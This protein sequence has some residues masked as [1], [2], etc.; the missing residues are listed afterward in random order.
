MCILSSNV[1][2]EIIKNHNIFNNRFESMHVTYEIPNF[3]TFILFAFQF[4]TS[5]K[6]RFIYYEKYDKRLRKNGV[7]HEKL[8]IQ[9]K[10]LQDN[11]KNVT[12]KISLFLF[13][14]HMD[15]VLMMVK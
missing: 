5:H 3:I 2:N 14:F 13:Y 6:K 8:T 11:T 4:T 12:F 1:V 9:S 15:M 10:G 7:G